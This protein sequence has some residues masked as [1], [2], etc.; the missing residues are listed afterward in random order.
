MSIDE[1]MSF[2]KDIVQILFWGVGAFLAVLSYQHAKVSIF[3]PAKN[4]V[5]KVQI[6]VLQ[7]LLKELNWKSSIESWDKSG[8]GTSAQIS[9]NGYFKRYA[10]D[11][12]DAE[13]SSEVEKNLVAVGGIFSP[14]AKGFQLVKGPA[15]EVE[16][17][18]ALDV[19][20][21][22]WSEFKWDIFEI[23]TE[24]QS[25]SDKIEGALNDPVLPSMILSEIENFREELHKSAMRAAED[26]EKA[27][28]Q[29]PRHYP[30]KESLNGATLTWAHN[31][32]EE[33]GEKLLEAL[34]VLKKSVRKYL[35]SDELLKHR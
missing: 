19:D 33:R 7:S 31:L 27:V 3:Q 24:F 9:L 5:F 14:S 30:T 26:V 1:L 32:R 13:M 34:N 11:Q 18:S 2:L 8:L 22:S 29:F 17:D 20:E 16:N 4:E 15:D 21:T 28:R 35:Q 12:H 25:L 23:S 6:A 10:K